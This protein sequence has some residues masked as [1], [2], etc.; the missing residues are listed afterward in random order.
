ME[1]PNVQLFLVGNKSDLSDK[2][3]VSKVAAEVNKCQLS[4]NQLKSIHTQAHTHIHCTHNTH[5]HTPILTHTHTPLQETSERIQIK[6]METSA[7][8]GENVE[9]LFES[10]VVNI[11]ENGGASGQGGSGGVDG[12]S[13]IIRVRASLTKDDNVKKKK[14]CSKN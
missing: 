1:N 5:T 6:Y 14:C 13:G 12:G 2:R 10:L 4:N 9:K 3:T 8:S 11:L 7:K